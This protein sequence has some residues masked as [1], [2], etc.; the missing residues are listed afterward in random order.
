MEYVGVH[1]IPF[2]LLHKTGFMRNF[3]HTV[4]ELVQQGMTLCGVERFIQ[5]MRQHN[6][7]S[8]A[9]Q[10]HMALQCKYTLIKK[11]LPSNDILAKCFMVDYFQNKDIYNFHM[12]QIPVKNV[13][14]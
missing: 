10:L 13:S 4:I 1:N 5:Q 14:P 11:P 3:V 9:L 6:A 7:L 8:I 12:S 2:I